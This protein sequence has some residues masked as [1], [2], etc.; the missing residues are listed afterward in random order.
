MKTILIAEDE[1]NIVDLAEAPA[2]AGRL[3]RE[4][5]AR[6]RAGAGA[7]VEQ[8]H[9]TLVLLDV[10]LPGMDGVRGLPGASAQNAGLARHRAS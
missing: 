7:T 8:V 3:H 6:R 9:R 2:R 4:G 5:G 1:P 10:M